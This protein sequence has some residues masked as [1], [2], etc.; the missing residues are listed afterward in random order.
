LLNASPVCSRL[1][2][3]NGRFPQIHTL[4]RPPPHRALMSLQQRLAVLFSVYLFI[5][6]SRTT[7]PELHTL[8]HSP[9]LIVPNIYHSKMQT[10]TIRPARLKDIPTML[11]L[12]K[13]AAAEQSPSATIKATEASL[14]STLTSTLYLTPHPHPHLNSSTTGPRFAHPLLLISPDDNH[15]PASLAIYLY[16]YST[17]MARPGVWKR[18]YTSFRGTERWGTRG[19]RIRRGR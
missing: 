9:E 1:Y 3:I 19:R 2:G 10:P 17:W 14:T 6:H 11:A 16:T 7:T 8:L 18:R 15:T 13:A 12:I 5:N 4:L